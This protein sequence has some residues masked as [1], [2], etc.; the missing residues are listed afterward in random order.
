MT[1]VEQNGIMAICGLC[2]GIVGF[3]ISLCTIGWWGTVAIV[4]FLMGNNIGQHLV[5]EKETEDK[6]K[7]SGNENEDA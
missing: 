5:R 6:L 4:L 2:F 7:E 1:K 3:I